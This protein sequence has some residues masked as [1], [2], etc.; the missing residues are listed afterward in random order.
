M[1]SVNFKECLTYQRQE[2]VMLATKYAQKFVLGGRA[3]LTTVLEIPSVVH[4]GAQRVSAAQKIIL[5]VL[6]KDAVQRAIP[7]F[8]GTTAV[9]LIASAVGTTAVHLIASAVGTTAVHLIASAVETAAVK[10]KT[11]VATLRIAVMKQS[12]VVRKE[13]LPLAATKNQ[14]LVAMEE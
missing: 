6:L 13:R 9:H 8:V 14:W 11:H 1:K 12:L 2:S 7:K 3:P 10:V 5:F 4:Q